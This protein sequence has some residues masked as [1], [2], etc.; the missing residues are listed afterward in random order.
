MWWILALLIVCIAIVKLTLD[1]NASRVKRPSRTDDPADD[2]T[3]T[4]TED[5]VTTV[6][7]RLDFDPAKAKAEWETFEKNR[8]HWSRVITGPLP[9]RRLTRSQYDC[10]RDAIARFR[11]VEGDPFASRGDLPDDVRLHSARTVRSLERHGF[12]E[13]NGRGALLCT[14]MGARAFEVLP[15]E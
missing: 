5:G 2:A 7:I 4:S 12:L 1:S 6:K 3:N 10:L 9:I 8:I 11:I 15:A 13:A 14:D